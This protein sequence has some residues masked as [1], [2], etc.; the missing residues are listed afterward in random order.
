MNSESL[1][2]MDE[3]RGLVS[4]IEEMPKTNEVQEQWV[5][6]IGLFNEMAAERTPIIEARESLERK[7]LVACVWRFMIFLRSLFKLR[8]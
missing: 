6:F 7:W 8:L 4:V 5:K 1:K 2:L 3:I